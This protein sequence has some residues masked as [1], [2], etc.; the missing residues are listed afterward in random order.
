MSPGVHVGATMVTIAL[1]VATTAFDPSQLLPL[2]P[3][4]VTAK[5]PS[6]AGIVVNFSFATVDPVAMP[7]EQVTPI[8]NVF[9]VRTTADAWQAALAGAT[10]TN[11]S[12][13]SWVMVAVSPP[14]HASSVLTLA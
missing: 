9:G 6:V 3:P 12:A 11:M 13:A 10:E 5:A 4:A 1:D 2:T 7:V 8:S 14:R